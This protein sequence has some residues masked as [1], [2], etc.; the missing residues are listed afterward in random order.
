MRALV[1]QKYWSV[2]GNCVQ[3][4]ELLMLNVLSQG[5]QSGPDQ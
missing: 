5:N 2:A 4:E 1:F 3:A